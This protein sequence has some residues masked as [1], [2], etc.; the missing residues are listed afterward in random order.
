MRTIGLIGCL[1]ALTAG[2]FVYYAQFT[3]LPAGGASPQQTIDLTAVRRTLLEIGRAQRIYANAHG[4]YGTLDQLR[5]EG[6]A[7]LG[8]DQRGY[9]FT[10]SVNGAQGFRATA[11][12]SG[13]SV[14]GSP[15]LAIDERMEI[16][17]VGK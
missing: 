11:T 8:A 10:V 1:I 15:S 4:T 3:R 12:P 2:Y 7:Q 16:L 6:A 13:A 9:V 14:P 5:A 17:T